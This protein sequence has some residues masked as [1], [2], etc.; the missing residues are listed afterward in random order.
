[1]TTQTAALAQ[2]ER[3]PF[4]I[5]RAAYWL[6]ISFCAAS[7]ICISA[8][9]MAGST[10][11]S[12]TG[13]NG[14]PSGLALSLAACGMGIA[15]AHA[16]KAIGALARIKPPDA[17]CAAYYAF[18]VCAIPMGEAFSFY[19]RIPVWDSVLHFSS[20]FMLWM[21]GALTIVSVLR[22]KGCEALITPAA[23]AV[24]A[25]AFA[26]S[27]G[28]VWEFFEF[29]MDLALGTNMQKFMMEDGTALV[30]QAALADTMKDLIV[31]CL[32]AL[33]ATLTFV[34]ALKA[35]KGWLYESG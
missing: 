20:G 18:I 17:L 7:M 33:A 4:P 11:P 1:M 21:L 30:G 6:A 26:L 13:A 3:K 19:Y 31:G 2:A 34:P 8:T 32:G 24:A 14:E 10:L 23:V 12:P 9:Y 25:V 15:L 29:S 16:P 22:R 27:V 35:G 28:A 5:E